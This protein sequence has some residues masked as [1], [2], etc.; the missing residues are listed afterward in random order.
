MMFLAI[1]IVF[2]FLGIQVFSLFGVLKQSPFPKKDW[3]E[4][5]R[6][7]ILLAAR[8]EEELIL[9]SL[10]HLSQLDYPKDKLEIWIGNDSSTDKTLAL[11]E[12]FIKD[13]PEFHVM[14]ISKNMGNGRGKAN[15]L[16]HLAHQ[17]NGD[18]FF[19]TDVDVALPKNWI[20]RILR[21][22]TEDVGIVSGTTTCSTDPNLFAR[23]QGMDWLHFMGYIKGMANFEISCTSVGNNMAV[24][25]EA[26]WQTGG[27]EKIPFSITE[28]YK[29]FEAV[30]KNGWHWATDLHPDSLGKAWYIPTFLEVL[31]QRKRWLIGARDLPLNWKS[32]LVLYGLFIPAWIYLLWINWQ[33]A[34]VLYLA[35]FGLQLIFISV[36]CKK[37]HLNFSW[38]L[39]FIYEL[40]LMTMVSSTA[41]FYLLPVKS[42]WKGRSYSSKNIISP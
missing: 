19:I 30:T 4:W 25:K 31:H 33:L 7:S 6:V 39:V 38:T 2:L 22:F 40:Y 26:Y 36:L 1:F 16:A 29:L 27:Y 5:P 8:N 18:Y 21:F 9:R 15:V 13:R 17:A 42:V 23:L 34:L 14:T 11:I 37:V 32:M 3:E 12:G 35:K 41:L 28:D 24:R 20:K 10:K